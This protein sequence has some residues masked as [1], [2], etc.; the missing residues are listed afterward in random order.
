[1][2]GMMALCWTAEGLSK[3]EVR[4]WVTVA[5]DASEEL[6]LE[7]HGLESGIDFE[8]FIGLDFDVVVVEFWVFGFGFG[9]LFDFGLLFKVHH[10]WLFK[11]IIII[12]EMSSD[13]FKIAYCDFFNDDVWW[14]AQSGK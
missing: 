10:L 14:Y 9:L 2:M 11:K 5:V 1:M 12:R 4:K 3:P 6:F 8:G 7:T 13:D